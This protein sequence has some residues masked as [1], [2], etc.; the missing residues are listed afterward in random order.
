MAKETG[1]TCACKLD[2]P[3]GAQNREQLLDTVKQCGELLRTNSAAWSERGTLG[4]LATARDTGLR[5]YAPRARVRPA[6]SIW[7]RFLLTMMTFR[8]SK[9]SVFLIIQK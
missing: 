6:S 7:I 4:H 3:V 5:K 9:I 8:A 2:S 1:E